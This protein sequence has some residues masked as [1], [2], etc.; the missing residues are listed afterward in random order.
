MR[1]LGIPELTIIM[2]VF[3]LIPV[4]ALILIYLVKRLRTNERLRAIE[5]GVSLP[6]AGRDPWDRARAIRHSGIMSLAAGPGIILIFVGIHLLADNSALL[7]LGLGVAAIPMLV[8]AGQLLEYYLRVRELE[9]HDPR[10]HSP[11]N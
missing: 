9:R 5:K 11:T 10:V 8:G 2:M 1:S 3:C 6:E 7:V 4:A